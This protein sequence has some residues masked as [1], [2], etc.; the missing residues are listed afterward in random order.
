MQQRESRPRADRSSE[1][2]N[3]ALPSPGR[4]PVLNASTLHAERD[5]INGV[6]RMERVRPMEKPKQPSPTDT[7]GGEQPSFDPMTPPAPVDVHG[8]SRRAG[9]IIARAARSLLSFS[10]GKSAGKTPPKRP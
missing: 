4:F 9:E 3:A 8:F 2:G 5:V 1:K 7:Q 10:G 6:P